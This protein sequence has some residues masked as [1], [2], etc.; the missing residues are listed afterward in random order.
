M[1]QE[2]FHDFFHYGGSLLV[3][4]VITGGIGSVIGWLCKPRTGLVVAITCALAAALAVARPISVGLPVAE[5]PLK[6]LDGFLISAMPAIVAAAYAGSCA[7]RRR[8]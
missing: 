3:W 7:A 8:G 2:L 4:L 5:T 6:L 1:L